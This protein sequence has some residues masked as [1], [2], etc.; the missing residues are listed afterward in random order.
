[1]GILLL[2]TS[3][4]SHSKTKEGQL[5]GHILR[6][7][8]LQ[9]HIIEG[10]TRGTRRGRRRRQ[11]L[12]A[13]EDA[14]RYWQLNEEAQDRTLWRAH[15]GRGKTDYYLNLNFNLVATRSLLST[16][17]ET[18]IYLAVAHQRTSGSGS[19]FRLLAITSQYAHI[20]S[21]ASHYNHVK[22]SHCSW[23]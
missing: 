22:S 4:S 5:D 7:N 11:L 3:C 21:H 17:T 8:C 10:K 23:A 18:S 13:L 19:T 1:M 12:D 16:V 9:K 2:A 6:T 20:S 14:R 15:F